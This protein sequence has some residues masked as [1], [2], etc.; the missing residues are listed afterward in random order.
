MLTGI[1]RVYVGVH[2]IHDVF[3][4]M[5]IGCSFGFLWHAIDPLKS[6]LETTRGWQAAWMAVVFFLPPLCLALVRH[7]VK[8]L[9]LLYILDDTPNV[10]R[11]KDQY[12]KQAMSKLAVG[13]T[14]GSNLGKGP[15]IEDRSLLKY[16]QFHAALCG[17]C[18]SMIGLAEYSKSLGQLQALKVQ[19]DFFQECDTNDYKDTAKRM[20]FGLG[21]LLVCYFL[22]IGLPLLLNHIL[23]TKG[24]HESMVVFSVRKFL[25]WF[26]AFLAAVWMPLNLTLTR[27]AG[28]SAACSSL[29]AS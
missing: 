3:F 9:G 19:Y 1:C 16:C 17:G 7:V 6:L 25:S 20:L 4:G 23:K 24:G 12:E 21:P 13:Q 29:P 10:H 15:E 14:V 5:A 28:I 22:A 18:A 8:F 26:G 27:V 2:Y 11:V